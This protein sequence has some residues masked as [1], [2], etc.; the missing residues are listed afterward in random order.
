V[1]YASLSDA[2]ELYG[3]EYVVT[4][5]DRDS[6]GEADT[7]AFGSALDKASS[8]IDTY[9]AK[10]YETPVS[11]AP[12]FLKQICID[13]A[14]YRSSPGL[15]RTDEKRERYNDAIRWLRDVSAGKATLATAVEAEDEAS[16]DLPQS[17]AETRLFTRNS[18]RSII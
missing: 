17:T 5:V 10:R 1:P 11:P 15:E 4:S 8:E 9:L 16:E 14:I 2:T 13:I 7:S 18:L 3:D 6:D 12:E